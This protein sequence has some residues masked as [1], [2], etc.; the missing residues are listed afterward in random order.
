MQIEAS[1]SLDF[2]ASLVY[3]VSFR[4]TRATQR[5]TV[6]K[7]ERKKRK[8]NGHSVLI[9]FLRRETGLKAGIWL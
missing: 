3:I 1:R 9:F 7:P 4:T 8:L 6:S 2:E 5:T